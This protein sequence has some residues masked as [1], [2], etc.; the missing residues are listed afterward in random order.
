[1]TPHPPHRLFVARLIDW[2]DRNCGAFR[3]ALSSRA[4]LYTEMVTAP[5]VVHG[6]RERLL[7]FDAVE[8]P[9]ALQLGGEFLHGHAGDKSC[10][11]TRDLA[12]LRHWC[13]TRCAQ[14]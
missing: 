11:R 9:V 1:M 8:H 13:R 5:A 14:R 3:G 12:R 10:V 2:T 7:G 6:D 4:L